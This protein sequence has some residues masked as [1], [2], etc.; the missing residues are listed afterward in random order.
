MTNADL[1]DLYVAYKVA[2]LGVGAVLVAG[3]ILGGLLSYLTTPKED[4]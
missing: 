1:L 4:P 3:A 2:A